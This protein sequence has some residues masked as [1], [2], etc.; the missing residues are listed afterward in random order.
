MM[1]V[2][3]MLVKAIPG[4]KIIILFFHHMCLKQSPHLFKPV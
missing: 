3:I 1:A 2:K 4:F